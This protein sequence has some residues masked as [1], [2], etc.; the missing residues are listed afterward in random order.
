M[1]KVSTISSKLFFKWHS[2]LSTKFFFVS[3]RATSV[4]KINDIG[5]LFLDITLNVYF[6]FNRLR[7]WLDFGAQLRVWSLRREMRN[8]RRRNESSNGNGRCFVAFS[9]KFSEQFF[10]LSSVFIRPQ[11]SS[12]IYSALPS[13][14][15]KS[16]PAAVCDF[17]LKNAKNP[18]K[19]YGVT[20]SARTLEFKFFV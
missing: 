9:D 6:N 11:H 14:F 13:T 5:G 12:S 10:F 19:L 17:H 7:L 20:S 8:E 15:R 18:P 1:G 4:R 3:T 16:R 2:A